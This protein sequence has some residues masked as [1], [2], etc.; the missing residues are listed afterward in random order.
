MTKMIQLVEEMGARISKTADAEQELVRALGEA[1]NRVDQK[2]LHNVQKITTEHGVRRGTILHELQG[3]AVRIGAFPAAR[4]VRGLEHNAP[5][6]RPV[7]AVT[8]VPTTNDMPAASGSAAANGHVRLFSGDW[9]Q[10]ANNIEDELDLYFK[11]RAS[12]SH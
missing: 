8:G 6:A 12:V 10:A 1:L 11:E 7:P 4:P 3:L 5:W 9:R 2:L